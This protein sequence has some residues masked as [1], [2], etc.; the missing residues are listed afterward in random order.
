MPWERM[1][2]TGA[3]AWPLWSSGGILVNSRTS[4][5]QVSWDPGPRPKRDSHNLRIQSNNRGTQAF[6]DHLGV[7]FQRRLG[8]GVAEVSLQFLHARVVLLVCRRSAP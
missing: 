1:A 6:G 7:V 8:V 3:A 4:G 2:A 5:M